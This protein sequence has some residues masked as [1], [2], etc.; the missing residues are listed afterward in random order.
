M[1]DE[2]SGLRGSEWFTMCPDLFAVQTQGVI[3]T[4]D[5]Y[6]NG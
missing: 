3:I 6:K 1:T 5:N 2:M 4:V